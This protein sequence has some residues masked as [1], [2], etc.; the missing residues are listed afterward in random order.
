MALLNFQSSYGQNSRLEQ[1]L[2]DV[3][4]EVDEF[5]VDTFFRTMTER[6]K[7]TMKRRR[8]EPW[9]W[10]DDPF[11]RD[12]KFTNVYRELD[13]NSQWEIN[14]IIK[15]QKLTDEDTLFHIL[16][17]RIFNQPD[18][19]EHNKKHRGWRNGIPLY[20]EYSREA[21][22]QAIYDYRA[23]GNNPFTNAYLTNSQS[24]PGQTRDW[25]YGNVIIPN[26]HERVPE[27]L[28]AIKT[29]ET[30]KE[31]AKM[32]VSLKS[33]GWFVAHEFYISLCYIAKYRKRSFWPWTEMDWTNVGPGASL[34]LRLIFPNLDSTSKQLEGIYWLHAMAESKLDEFG[35]EW[36]DER[37][38][39]T[40]HQIE[41]WLCE[42]GK[43]YKM[44]V[45]EGKQRS[46]Y[47][48]R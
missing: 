33:A 41:F 11:L 8:G 39:F 48:P 17:F 1:G 26:Y 20:R 2:P 9:P 18:F 24:C 28:E 45:G 7:V 19:F 30:A 43:Y 13:R 40:L 34:G 25:C 4:C 3:R 12:Y 6:Q 27:I 47:S 37:R 10:T 35:F 32:L 38:E 29:H 42:Y 36:L 22:E 5:H 31:S 44:M 46:K 15:N 21:F 16:V 14:N 23:T